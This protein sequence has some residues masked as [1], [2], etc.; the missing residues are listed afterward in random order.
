[1]SAASVARDAGR[2]A[3]VYAPE[4]GAPTTRRSTAPLTAFEPP[5]VRANVRSVDETRNCGGCLCGAVRYEISG[6][7]VHLSICHCESCRRAIGAPAVPWATFALAGFRVTRGEIAEYRSSPAVTRGFCAR[8]GC[9]LTYRHEGRADQIDVTLVTLDAPARFVP[10]TH[11]WV[12]DRLPWESI[13]D[14]LPQF[15][16][17]IE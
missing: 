15:A 10:L 14:G 9:S 5:D 11:V 16:A 17:D 7:A 1:M 8:C 3:G 12:G 6:A 13:D 4:R 2:G